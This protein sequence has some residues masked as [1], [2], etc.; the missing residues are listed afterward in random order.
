MFPDYVM[1]ATIG[2]FV[3]NVRKMERDSWLK[4]KHRDDIHGLIH[5]LAYC[6]PTA[7]RFTESLSKLTD[8]SEA[9]IGMFVCIHSPL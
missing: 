2:P 9:L 3:A 6:G 8:V 1:G 5:L 4:M 7:L